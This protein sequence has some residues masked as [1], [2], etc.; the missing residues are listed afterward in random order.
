MQ[1]PYGYPASEKKEY[2]EKPLK[3]DRFYFFKSSAWLARAK[4]MDRFYTGF[5]HLYLAHIKPP[6]VILP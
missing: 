4:D 2:F 5:Y 1:S 6:N 3:Q